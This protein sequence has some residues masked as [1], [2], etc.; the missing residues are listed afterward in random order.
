MERVVSAEAWNAYGAM[1]RDL[2][3][4]VLSAAP[5]AAVS[6]ERPVREWVSRGFHGEM[7]WYARNLEK[8]LDPRLIMPEARSVLVA[9]ALS[10]AQPLRLA[11]YRLARYAGGCDYHELLKHRMMSL[12]GAMQQGVGQAS[13]RVYVDT[14][15]ILERY[16]AQQAGA[17]W[18]GRMGQLISTAHGTG[19]LLATALTDL[20]VPYG[21]P[22]S[23][24]CGTCRACV[25]SCPTGAIRDGRLVDSRRCISYLSIEYRG[26]SFP[27]GTDLHGWAFGCDLCQ[28]ACPWF[29]RGEDGEVLKALH[30]RPEWSS[31]TAKQILTMTDDV[32]AKVFKGSPIKRA[33]R[34][35]LQRNVLSLTAD[36]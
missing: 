31:L 25:D 13:F 23:D 5:A 36:R 22:H 6:M 4:A 34:V 21:E 28:E 2:G 18:V 12:C 32:F 7:H 8:R 35:G 29:K 1:A 10:H 15:P 33:R 9:A 11:G 3:F 26:A 16:W 30:P 20:I 14:G 17:G 24:R 19:L 27:E